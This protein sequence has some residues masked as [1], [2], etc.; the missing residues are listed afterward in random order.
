M[1]SIQMKPKPI[2]LGLSLG[3]L[4]VAA[5]SPAQEDAVPANEA[6]DQ[7]TLDRWAEPY[8][9]WHYWP[10]HVIPSDPNIPG[11]EEFHNTD[12]PTIYQIPEKPDVWFMSFIGFDGQGYNSFVA[13]STDLIHW[14][15]P[16]L[17]FGFG[18]EGQFDHGG[19]VVGAYLYESHGL[20]DPRL[21]A[22]WGSPATFW[23]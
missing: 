1:S 2:L 15:N 13:E 23:T 19:R 17:A 22:K 7:Q 9:G 12:C 18:P 10:D 14:T 16:R 4:F 6:I 5:S 20:R 8:R 21:L 11:H 3:I